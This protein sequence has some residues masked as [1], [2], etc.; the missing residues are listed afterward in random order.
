MQGVYLVGL[1]VLL[2]LLIVVAFCFRPKK[3]LLLP[4]ASVASKIIQKDFRCMM[5]TLPVGTTVDLPVLYINLDRSEARRHRMEKHLQEVKAVYFERVPGIDGAKLA[6]QEQKLDQEKWIRSLPTD[7]SELAALIGC[8]SSLKTKLGELGCTLSHLKAIVQAYDR[9]LGNVLIIEDDADLSAE[10]VW[11]H[12][13]QEL[14]VAAAE[15]WHVLSLYDN[16]LIPSLSENAEIY[17]LK[18]CA[19]SGTVAYLISEAGQRVIVDALEKPGKHFSS[20]PQKCMCDADKLI[21]HL[22][23]SCYGY[24][25]PMISTLNNFAELDSTIH[26]DHT[27]RHLQLAQNI[28][29]TQ[30][31]SRGPAN[32]VWC[33]WPGQDEMPPYLE[34]CLRSWKLHNEPDNIEIRLLTPE[35]IP[36]Y[37]PRLHPAYSFL[38]YV[39]RSDYLRAAVLHAYGGLYVDIDSICLASARSSLKLLAD[40]DVVGYDGSKWGEPWGLS[41]ML[42]RPMTPFTTAWIN[43]VEALLTSKQKHLENYRTKVDASLNKDGLEWTELLRDIV[44]PLMQKA[45]KDP[46]NIRWTLAPGDWQRINDTEILETTTTDYNPLQA[47]KDQPALILNNSL[48]PDSVKQASHEEITRSPLKLFRVLHAAVRHA[49]TTAHKKKRQKDC[50]GAIYYIN[51]EHRRDRRVAVE[52]VLRTAFPQACI[53]RQEA[54][55]D[56]VM[57]ERGCLRS[58]C[59]VLRRSLEERPGE[60]VLICEDDLEFLQGDV[61]KKLARTLARLEPQWDVLMLSAHI[62]KLSGTS[63]IALKCLGVSRISDAQSAAC[64]LVR[65]DYVPV[66]LR[67][68]EDALEAAKQHGWESR[69]HC[70]DRAWVPLQRN[71]YWYAFCKCSLARQRPGHSDIEN[72]KVDYIDACRF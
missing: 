28:L 21:Y 40:H 48:Y 1:A 49:E 10:A 30:L 41:A 35:T 14:T 60:N 59:S 22:S 45:K 25:Y 20:I 17:P 56:K 66:L 24:S 51:L 15:G 38:S 23:A 53:K 9:K 57:P 37:L 36:Q 72:R 54:V 65:A 11:P 32:C 33:C 12:S 55:E 2:L 64:Y 6:S 61:N 43:Q 52:R 7:P 67:T 13:L 46:N 8:D 27:V 19:G 71:D 29:S 18:K 31:R 50:V 62:Q 47:L 4:E 44:L 26:T 58:H 16:N 70:S 68:Y 3:T 69:L 63:P 5:R 42:A 34:Q 39:H